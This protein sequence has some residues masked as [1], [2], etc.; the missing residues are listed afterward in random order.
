MDKNSKYAKKQFLREHILKTLGFYHP[1]CIDPKGGF[2]QHFRDDGALYLPELRH[3]VSTTRF[4][5]NYAM[6]ALEFEIP[7]FQE[8]VK[9]GLKYLESQHFNKG[10]G[11]YAWVLNGDV[12][13]DD[14]NHCYGLAFVLLAYAV[15]YKAG[16]T[17]ASA[18]IE[19]TWD[20]LETRYWESEYNLY[21]DE[22]NGDFSR[23]E[24]YRGQ[25]ANMHM[26]EAMLT[27]YDA[28]GKT[29]F[30]DRAYTIARCITVELTEKTDGFI[31]EHYTSDW[32]VDWDYN[33]ND[34]KHL[35]RP[36]GFLS[37]HHTE[38]TKLLT[39]LYRY[40]PES[41][42]LERAEFFFNKS[43]EYAWDH[44]NGGIYYIFDPDLKICDTDKYFWV[45][46]ETFA[47]A[48]LLAIVT[49]KDKYWQWYEKIW[50]YCDTHMIDHKY[51]AWFRILTFD[52][53]KYS[54]EKSP[55]GKTDYH[56]MGACYE[57]IRALNEFKV[58]K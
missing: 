12:V 39:I 7:D 23:V 10:T 46:A 49:G 32:Q 57:V 48:A 38:W 16:V 11:G 36:W 25:N 3:L 8:H 5:F 14:T 24:A 4:V 58:R 2:F 42:M 6:A 18:G 40:K 19:R 20:L 35:F 50:Q 34:P 1:G 22:I 41:W 56:T 28:T 33:K 30:L 21:K 45:Q 13:E 51:G 37:G 29:K 52:N 55:A 15:A 44:K 31:W 47:A 54:D 17:E 53:K 43:L 27:C 9:H 26:C